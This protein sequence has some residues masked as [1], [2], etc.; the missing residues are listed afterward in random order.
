[1]KTTNRFAGH[2]PWV[3]DQLLYAEL[4]SHVASLTHLI[5]VHPSSGFLPCYVTVKHHC[6]R[7]TM[8]YSALHRTSLSLDTSTNLGCS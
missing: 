1:M 6:R 2:K 4:C 8:A 7:N 5:R 3:G